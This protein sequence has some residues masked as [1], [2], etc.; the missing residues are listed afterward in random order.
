MFSGNK[1]LIDASMRL[2]LH[3]KSAFRRRGIVTSSGV[4]A[5]RS[6][7]G[8]N[9]NRM[10]IGAS[11]ASM[12]AV[13][14][15]IENYNNNDEIE[16]TMSNGGGYERMDI[17]KIVKLPKETLTICESRPPP[18]AIVTQQS[19]GRVPLGTGLLASGPVIKEQATGIMFPGLINGM[20]LVGTGVRIKF[21][22]AKVYAVGT[23]MDPVAMAAI[24]S[25]PK[26]EIEQALL[27]PTYPRVIRIVLYRNL[28]SKQFTD[29]V[30]ESLE[31]RMHNQDMW[32]LEEFRKF[33]DYNG[34]LVEGSQVCMTIR[35]DTLL[36]E[37][38]NGTFGQI[39]S[40]VFCKAM[41]DIYYGQDPVSPTHK[42]AVIDGI[43]KQM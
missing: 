26:E 30:V 19:K 15:T 24:K 14:T 10:V 3:G 31:P 43:P 20:K 1:M 11:M 8:R 21:V 16:A 7:S 38:P 6:S 4:V 12:T 41:C 23:Y 34:K 2:G 42:Q 36:Y 39:R 22:F 18:G 9:S 5:G 32:A 27:N 37:S 33:N 25:R 29:A 13:A 40:E 17:F 28:T 35:G